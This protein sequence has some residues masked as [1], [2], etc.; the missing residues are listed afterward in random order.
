M[1]W[2]LYRFGVGEWRR[3]ASWWIG[4]PEVYLVA[5]NTILNH[6]KVL[7]SFIHNYFSIGLL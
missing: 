6:E 4:L 5:R 7:F 2:G 3:I 1:F